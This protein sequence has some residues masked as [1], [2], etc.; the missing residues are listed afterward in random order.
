MVAG[1][2]QDDCRSGEPVDRQAAKRVA[3]SEIDA[4]G[5]AT[6]R[7]EGYGGDDFVAVVAGRV[8]PEGIDP[9]SL[10]NLGDNVRDGVLQWDVPP[11][12]WKVMR[13]SWVRAPRAEQG[14]FNFTGLDAIATDFHLVIHSS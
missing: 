11:G 4:V 14:G 1:T 5:G 12:E 8:T 3:G 6:F 2:P 9:E 10:A 7:A 13:F